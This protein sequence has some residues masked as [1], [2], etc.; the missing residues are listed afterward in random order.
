MALL[1]E[2]AQRRRSAEP[3]W[4]LHRSSAR[5]G[6]TA[7]ERRPY[8]GF[9]PAV[10]VATRAMSVTRATLNAQRPPAK[11][12][13]QLV[14]AHTQWPTLFGGGMY[15]DC[16]M[17]ACTRALAGRIDRHGEIDGAV[18]SSCRGAGV[19]RAEVRWNHVRAELRCRRRKWEAQLGMRE[20]LM[21]PPPI[22]PHLHTHHA[23]AH[24]C[25]GTISETTA[26][27]MQW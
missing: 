9:L 3:T 13:P 22:W 18:P 12:D 1:I 2:H 23:H 11:Y 26:S 24:A 8:C 7:I 14:R 15:Q 17:H 19:Q 20:V 5:C 27:C 25:S 10:M 4:A 6:M 21:Q 16:P